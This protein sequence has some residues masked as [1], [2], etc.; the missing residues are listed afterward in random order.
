[1]GQGED[2]E[3]SL[4]PPRGELSSPNPWSHPGLRWESP[5]DLTLAPQQIDGDRKAQ[6]G[7]GTQLGTHSSSPA[8][9]LNSSPHL[10][11]PPLSQQ[12]IC[13]CSKNTI[14][15]QGTSSHSPA[16]DLVA[17]TR[18]PPPAPSQAPGGGF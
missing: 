9:H 12:L 5:G 14:W 15:T 13:H 10:L 18:P 11:E 16:L 1:M 8:H 6:R 2:S 3:G 7:A 17:Q 4:T